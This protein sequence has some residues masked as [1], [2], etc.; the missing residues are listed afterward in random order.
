ML[1]NLAAIEV[2]QSSFSQVK[3]IIVRNCVIRHLGSPA[4]TVPIVGI[5]MEQPGL[6][7]QITK[8]EIRD[9]RTTSWAMG[10]RTA[11]SWQGKVVVTSNDV[12]NVQGDS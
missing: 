1:G 8:N 9:F 4:S 10:I 6:N 2:Y 11:E 3:D 7:I 12:I 5:N